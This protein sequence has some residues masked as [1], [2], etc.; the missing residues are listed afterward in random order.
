MVRPSAS[1]P[2]SLAGTRWDPVPSGSPG[3]A[4]QPVLVWHPWRH[5]RSQFILATEG[6]LTAVRGAHAPRRGGRLEA[7]SRRTPPG[8]S[9]GSAPDSWVSRVGLVGGSFGG[10]GAP[11]ESHLQPSEEEQASG[12]RFHPGHRDPS[13]TSRPASKW[14]SSTGRGRATRRLAAK[15]HPPLHVVG[16]GVRIVFVIPATAGARRRGGSIDVSTRVRHTFDADHPS[17][18]S[19]RPS[20]ATEARHSAGRRGARWPA[21]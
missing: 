1:R 17:G 12:G 21:G 5:R 13:S 19:G 2:S 6:H 16:F 10:H 14:W 11:K 3:R 15:L 4:Q 18:K 9:I 8:D 7:R 20:S